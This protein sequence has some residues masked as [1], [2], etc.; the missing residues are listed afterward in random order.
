MRISLLMI[1][2]TACWVV[3]AACFHL[4][5]RADDVDPKISARWQ[6]EPDESVA[7]VGPKGILWQFNYG[8]NFSKP[9]FH[10]VALSSGEVLTWN[11][12]PDH[13]WHLA[14]WFSWK[15]INDI[16]YWEENSQTGQS[17]GETTWSNVD[18]Q[19]HDDGRASISMDLSYQVPGE[20]PVLTERR[21]V[22]IFAPD[23]NNQQ[24]QMDW[25]STFTAGA[26]D[27][28]LDRTDPA[29]KPWG[30]YA[31]LSIRF[32]KD[33]TE[34]QAFSANG[35]AK[36][37][38]HSR[39]RSKSPALDYNGKIGEAVGGIAILDH[40]NN[41]RYPTPWYAIRSGM[42]Y[43]NA[44]FLTYEPYTL[45]AGE[46]FTLRYRLIIHPD[47]LDASALKAVSTAFAKQP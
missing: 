46:F 7:R 10:P 37:N 8:K 1:A 47:R 25:S 26:V 40:P 29:D 33:L 18:I 41:P 6:L 30:G 23:E 44:A 20:Q 3:G 28:I 13:A 16:N 43:L 9:C 36:F 32:A 22:Q 11:Q 21:T 45:K 14:L 42:S 5:V 19:T 35:P 4:P 17:A 2:A 27:V 12:P 31:G 34:R 24:Y 38:E 39:H 15:T